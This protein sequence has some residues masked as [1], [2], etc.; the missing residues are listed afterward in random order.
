MTHCILHCLKTCLFTNTLDSLH[1]ALSLDLPLHSLPLLLELLQEPLMMRTYTCLQPHS[2][3]WGWVRRELSWE[4]LYPARLPEGGQ[5]NTLLNM[6]A[7][8]L[9]LFFCSFLKIAVH[10]FG[11]RKWQLVFRFLIVW[12]RIRIL[13]ALNPVPKLSHTVYGNQ[14]EVGNW[15]GFMTILSQFL[16]RI[17]IHNFVVRIRNTV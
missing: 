12:M 2:S 4:W 17:R 9:W 6:K 3:C 8:F 13:T 10:I 7:F 15:A 5:I 16:E 14:A 1:P 11:K